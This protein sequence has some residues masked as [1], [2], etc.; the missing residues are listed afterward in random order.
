[1][2]A[3]ALWL[4]LLTGCCIIDRSP[5][6][7]ER[8]VV[9]IPSDPETLTGTYLRFQTYLTINRD[10]TFTAE[11]HGCFGVDGEAAGIWTLE[12]SRIT[13][14]PTAKVVSQGSKS[15]SLRL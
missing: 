7:I 8:G 5:P 10:T 6:V 3:F 4:T 11:A 15:L 13:S 2:F 9:E 14:R 1:M 12:G